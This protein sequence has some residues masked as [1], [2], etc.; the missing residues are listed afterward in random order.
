MTTE[1]APREASALAAIF[2]KAYARAVA[3]QRLDEQ[4]HVMLDQ[5]QKLEAE[6]REAQAEVNDECE[7]MLRSTS[8]APARMLAHLAEAEATIQAETHLNGNGNGRLVRARSA[9]AAAHEGSR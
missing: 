4:I 7:R 5:R 1:A 3:L 9:A 2:Q 6:F 8:V